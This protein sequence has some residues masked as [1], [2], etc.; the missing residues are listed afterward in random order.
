MEF[1][2]LIFQKLF[3]L[4]NKKTENANQAFE[5]PLATITSKL[6]IF[7]RA[8][9]GAPINIFASEREGGWQGNVFYLP[10]T[11]SLYDAAELNI[12]FYIFRLFY[13]ITQKSLQLN[14]PI[15]SDN[16][17]AKSQQQAIDQSSKVL[18]KLF[19]E[20]PLL[21][22]I[23]QEL[24]DKFPFQ[25]A[26]KGEK[27]SQDFSWLYGRW[28]KNVPSR[29]KENQ[30]KN[31]NTEPAKS[32]AI[33]PKTV[34]EAQKADEVE[35]LHV[36]KKAQEDYMLT[37]NFEKID[38]VDEFDGVWRD[39]DG[40]DSLE[41]DLEALQEYNLKHM[42]RVDDPV[43]SVYQADYVSNASIA[44]SVAIENN[45]FHLLYPEW[46][47]KK[48]QYEY[49]Y[50]KVF[51]KKLSGMD[52]E[53][54]VKTIE[55]NRSLLV[56]LKKTFAQLNNKWEQSRRQISGDAI[57]IDAATDLFTDIKAHRTPDERI[58]TKK[59]KQA[60]ELGLLF[61]LDLSLSSDA[62]ANGNRI[63]DVEKQISILFGE[64]LNEYGIDFQIDGFYS[65]T[66]NNTA[67]ITLKAFNEPW[68]KART[69]I[70]AAEATGYTRIGPAIRHA[71][72]ILEKNPNRKRW[73]I[74]LSDGKP[75]DY[76]KYEGKHGVEDI[77][78]SLRE[79]RV[80]GINNFAFAIEEQ[81]KFYLPQMFG[82]NHYNILTSPVELLNSLTKLYDR[83]EHS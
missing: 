60:K 70:G 30:I 38:T 82:E 26:K 59:R 16:S 40:D 11:V 53:Y 35:I 7:A 13:L 81:A 33:N 25:P 12:R 37:N 79:M 47:Y 44:E 72:S 31:I 61:L 68:L 14:W 10:K 66:R 63:I 29:E 9:S 24:K 71:T 39:F 6:T 17:I 52:N 50:C 8:L 5:V 19:E 54:F 83:I 36:D 77:K 58:Y 21:E 3:K 57:D 22:P 2:Q 42:V 27:S 46:D 28:M 65:K 67:Y 1:D 56:R 51:P 55:Q 75:N 64:V 80:K 41:E 43:H 78:Q 23:Y 49:D 45:N 4:F 32:A 69:R 73:L 48:R 74:L 20:Y 15:G 62:Y 34:I 18:K 76:D